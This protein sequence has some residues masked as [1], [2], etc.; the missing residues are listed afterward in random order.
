MNIRAVLFAGL[1]MAL[2]YGLFRQAPPP[3]LFEQSDKA[4]H[5]LAFFALTFSGCLALPSWSGVRFWSLFLLLGPVLEVAQ[6]WF[7]PQ[8]IFSLED[9]LANIAGTLLAGGLWWLW[10][11]GRAVAA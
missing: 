8:R 7:Q 4:M 9:A 10:C 3:E 11:R 1:C 5:L 2:A 6:H